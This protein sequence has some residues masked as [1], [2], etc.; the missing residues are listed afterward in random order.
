MVLS[1]FELIKIQHFTNAQLKD[2]LIHFIL[3]QT[4]MP[5]YKTKAQQI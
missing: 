4:S 2:F 5:F 3:T 1:Y